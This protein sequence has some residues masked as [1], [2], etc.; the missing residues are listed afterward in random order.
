[1]SD[2][3]EFDKDGRFD[4]ALERANLNRN[5][6]SFGNMQFLERNFDDNSLFDDHDHTETHDIYDKVELSAK[7]RVERYEKKLTS[8]KR[9][10]TEELKEERER[11]Q[12]AINNDLSA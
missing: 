9:S 4:H 2:N 6:I 12:Q 1:M 5:N 8:G 11:A 10:W 7:E 3:K